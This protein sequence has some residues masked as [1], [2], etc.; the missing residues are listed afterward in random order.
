M[1]AAL[2]QG[3]VSEAQLPA[4]MADGASLHEARNEKPSM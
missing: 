1:G 4:L 2:Q 3:A